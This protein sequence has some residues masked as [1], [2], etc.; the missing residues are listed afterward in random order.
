MT[1]PPNTQAVLLLTAHF[2]KSGVGSA[3]PL[4]T[5]EW[6]RFAVWLK[7]HSLTPEDLLC[8]HVSDALKGWADQQ[9]TLQ[10]IEALLNRGAALALAMEKWLRAG[11]WVLTRS[12][13]EYPRPLKERLGIDSP[14]IVFG[15]GN[16]SLLIGGGLAIVGSRNAGK[17]DIQYTR[18]VAQKVAAE[19]RSIVS[20]GAR[21]V[22]EAAMLGALEREGTVVGVLADSLLGA[23]SSAKY[24]QH[25]IAHNLALVSTFHPEAGFSAGNAMQRNKYV[26]CLSDAA[27]VVHSGKRGGT[28]NGAT[29]NLKRK[30]VVLWVKRNEDSNA[31]NSELV[32]RGGSWANENPEAISVGELCEISLQLGNDTGALFS[33]ESRDDQVADSKQAESRGTF[34]PVPGEALALSKGGVAPQLR[35]EVVQGE[36]SIAAARG[37]ATFYEFFLGR[38]EEYSRRSPKTPDEVAEFLDLEKSQTNTWLKRAVNEDKVRKLFRPVRYQWANSRQ[39]SLGVDAE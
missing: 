5:K 29:E 6:G 10:R 39:A 7:D 12:D 37:D 31:G 25:L 26:Y 34:D 16:K 2:S 20:G 33:A 3:K 36:P 15:C 28:W 21:G 19:G 35:D 14:P 1:L 8:G 32:N 11:L 22:D 23:S 18:R 38:L 17:D 24:R 30:W 4:T 9:V 13:S 27:L